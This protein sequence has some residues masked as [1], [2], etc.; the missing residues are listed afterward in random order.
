MH[1]DHAIFLEAIAARRK[2]SVRFFNKAKEEVV[3]ICAPLDYG[4]LR[5]SPDVAD[6][7]QLWDLDAKRKPFNVT[8][9]E[10]EVLGMTAQ[11]D[12]FDPATIITWAFKPH[13]WRVPRDWAEFS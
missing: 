10:E 6:R 9:L 3:R 11:D 4:P 12:T 5:G 1:A 8:L 7:Y 2:L 13:A